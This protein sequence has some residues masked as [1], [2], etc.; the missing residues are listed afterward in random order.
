MTGG[1]K[2]RMAFYYLCFCVLCAAGCGCAGKTGCMA[3]DL[4]ANYREN[5]I[6]IE[7][8]PVFSWKMLDTTK[9]QRQTA[10]R[11]V[12]ADSKEALADGAYLWDS[13]MV[14]SGKSVAVPY[15]GEGL[16]AETRYYWKVFVCH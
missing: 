4:T 11:I 2:I 13:G 3:V 10:Y 5:P 1:Q 16:L 6:G 9:G 12:V 15:G 7:A 14:T 8:E